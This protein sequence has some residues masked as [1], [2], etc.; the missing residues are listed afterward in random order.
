MV[1]ICFSGPTS[2]LPELLINIASMRKIMIII[3]TAIVSMVGLLAEPVVTDKVPTFDQAIEIIKK[4][5]GMHSARHWPFVGYGHK[6]LPTDKYKRGV[7]LTEAQA[8]KLLRDDMKK[9]CARYRSYGK[10]SLLLA[11]LAYNVGTGTVGKSSVLSKL[12]AGDRDIREV[13]VK[14]CRYRGKV[15][16]QIQRR[17]NEEFD[18]LYVQ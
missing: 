9:L 13:Y 2:T 7:K 5:E 4:Y 3:A 6:V 10:D 11:A 17:R 14:H 15:N 18:V 16:S 1:N 8:D 12:N